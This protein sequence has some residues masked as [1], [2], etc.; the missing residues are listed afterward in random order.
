LHF[1][2]GAVNC[3][4]QAAVVE[5]MQE[6]DASKVHLVEG[7]SEALCLKIGIL[8]SLI[9]SCCAPSLIESCCA[10]ASVQMILSLPP[11]PGHDVPV[12][13]YFFLVRLNFC[14]HQLTVQDWELNV[15]IPLYSVATL[16]LCSSGRSVVLTRTKK[17]VSDPLHQQCPKS[18]IET[19]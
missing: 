16:A 15:G 18:R 14:F 6:S 10:D 9:E 5:T 19:L 2:T 12:Y 7:T 4:S 3:H 8:P 11:S 17:S 13:L 1:D